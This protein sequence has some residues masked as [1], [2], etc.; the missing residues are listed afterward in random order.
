MSVKSYLYLGLIGLVLTSCTEV[1]E[2][3]LEGIE[4]Q[5]VIEAEVDATNGVAIVSLTQSQDLYN[6]GAFTALEGAQVELFVDG[7]AISIPEE[8]AGSYRAADLN[9]N[10]GQELV[11]EV[12]LADGQQFTASSQVPNQ[13]QFDTLIVNPALG[14]GGGFGNPMGEGSDEPMYEIIVGW[15]DIPEEE[16]FYRV[17][18]YEDDQFLSDAYLLT[19]DQLG[20]GGTIT[21]LLIGQQF[22]EGA[23]LRVELLTTSEGY[24]RYFTDIANRGGFGGGGA[25]TPYNPTSN[26][27]GDILGFFGVW[28]VVEQTVIAE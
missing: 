4:P 25:A 9:L 3:D 5:V 12:T 10:S 21:R 17:K 6:D 1:I 24:F 13:A 23:E 20:E 16:N 22:P 7:T 2:L 19:D 27:S 18:L 26:F 8:S 15:D 28:Q 11:M 14:L